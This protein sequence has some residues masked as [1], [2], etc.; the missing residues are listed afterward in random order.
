MHTAFRTA[1]AAL[2]ALAANVA[3]A[4]AEDVPVPTAQATAMHAEFLTQ[5]PTPATP[6]VICIVD[7]G[8]NSNPDTTAAVIDRQTLY[9]GDVSDSDV[10]AHHG[11]YLAM[12][13][14]GPT[15]GWGMVGIA[16][17]TRILSIRA[18]DNGAHGFLTSAYTQGINR[19]IQAKLNDAMNIKTVLLALG[20]ANTDTTAD[21]QALHDGIESARAHGITVVAAAGDDSQ[22]VQWPARYGTALAVAAS[23]TRGGVCSSSSRGP[24]VDID[25]LGCGDDSAIWDTGAPAIIDGS[26]TSAGLVAGVLSALRA[27]RSDLSPDEGEQLLLSTAESSGGRKVINVA[28][29][30]RAAGLGGMVDAYQPPTPDVS[31]KPPVITLGTICPDGG[32]LSCQRPKLAS[33]TRKHSSVVLTVASLPSGS[34]L[35]AKVRRRWHTSTTTTIS[36]KASHWKKILVRFAS[37][38]GE[39]SHTL[40]VRPSNLSKHHQSRA[41]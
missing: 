36:L 31:P 11:T 6:G 32:V 24:E 22:G 29:A 4:R 35:Q 38:D 7:S 8:V 16:P 15:N 25:A 41:A 28:A 33:A 3:V 10:D 5:A 39:R 13:I 34:F 9:A 37:I 40:T 23:D 30:F 12:N 14:A 2:L 20:R 1:T 17:Q 27:Y 19:C 18:I 26:G 21:G